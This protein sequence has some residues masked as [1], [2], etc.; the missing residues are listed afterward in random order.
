MDKSFSDLR[1]LKIRH[2]RTR[3]RS[4]V[5]CNQT[6]PHNK[7][8]YLNEKSCDICG[9]LFC[10][11]GLNRRKCCNFCFKAVCVKCSM[12][13]FYDHK[14]KSMS[15]C[16]D[17]CQGQSI[18]TDVSKNFT[19]KIARAN[20][21]LNNMKKQIKKEQETILEETNLIEELTQRIKSNQAE[22]SNSHEKF[23]KDAEDLEIKNSKIK[24]KI[25][26]L[27]LKLEKLI[28]KK[29]EQSQNL[30]IIQRDINNCQNEFKNFSELKAYCNGEYD[31]KFQIV[32]RG[33]EEEFFLNQECEIDLEKIT[34]KLEISKLQNGY[35]RLSLEE[36]LENLA[37]KDEHINEMIINSEKKPIISNSYRST[38]TSVS[39]CIQSLKLRDDLEF[40]QKE[41]LD[42]Q[43]KL[44]EL[45]SDSKPSREP[46]ASKSCTC[47]IQ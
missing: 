34:N 17:N 46:I 47:S 16:C 33:D 10:L 13:K 12:Q 28:D 43:L 39:F 26:D 5:V 18:Q 9:S 31:K 8:A 20:Y 7:S 19:V 2:Q 22:K 32:E 6:P 24:K 23:V 3:S 14:S 27:K 11:L 35:L 45:R 44:E 38:A 15:R 1:S 40:K 21:D 37:I 41:I 30:K 36:Y 29:L 25:H 42:L 4:L